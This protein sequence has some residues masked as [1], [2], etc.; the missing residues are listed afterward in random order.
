MNHNHSAYT[1]FN[2]FAWQFINFWRNNIH[3]IKN[4]FRFSFGGFIVI[5]HFLNKFYFPHSM[6]KYWIHSNMILVLTQVLFFLSFSM[7]RKLKCSH[8][9]NKNKM[10]PKH[11]Y[12]NYKSTCNVI[13]ISYGTCIQEKWINTNVRRKNSSNER[14]QLSLYIWQ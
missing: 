4:T 14:Y 1:Q 9:I 6:Q 3:S 13:Y 8:R 12:F 2:S 10:H 7:H 11:E 5:I